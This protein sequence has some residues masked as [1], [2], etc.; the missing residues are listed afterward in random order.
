M[1]DYPRIRW[2]VSRE[3]E[4]YEIYYQNM[5]Y[6]SYSVVEYLD[7]IYIDE[8]YQQE[9]SRYYNTPDDHIIIEEVKRRYSI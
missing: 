3:F 8:L 6:D 2:C 9:Y 4:L 1:K 7:M 5:F